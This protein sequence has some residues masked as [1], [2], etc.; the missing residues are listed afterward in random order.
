MTHERGLVPTILPFGNVEAR[1]TACY[2]RDPVEL[3]LTR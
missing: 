3:A 1:K 2:R